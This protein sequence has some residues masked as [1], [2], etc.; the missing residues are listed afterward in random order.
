[1][2]A[3]F[4]ILLIV[5]SSSFSYG[6][7]AA[8][9]A[10]KD[11][12]ELNGVWAEAVTKGDGA[13]LEKIFSDDIVVTAG[14]GSIRNKSEEIKDATAGTDPDFV[15]VRP[16]TTENERVKIF[17][18]AA[19]VTGLVKWAFKYKGQEVNQERRYSHFYVKEKGQWRIVAQHVSSNLYKKP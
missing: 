8:T 12:L 2:K 10:E 16:F 3:L 4:L 7:T 15:W 11:L 19:V 14:N 1:M 18:D 17:N 13:T 5:V 9:S 6:Q